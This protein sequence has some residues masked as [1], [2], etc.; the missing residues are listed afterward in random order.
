MVANLLPHP[1]ATVD[2][3]LF[4]S[5]V[6]DINES[7]SR[8]GPPSANT[9]RK[10]SDSAFQKPLRESVTNEAAQTP[11]EAPP[12]VEDLDLEH[13][14]TSH[15]EKFHGVL[16][17]FSH[18]WDGSLG[19][20]RATKH[21]IYLIEDAHPIAC[22]PYRA[23]PKA[24]EAEQMEVKRM[25]AANVIESGQSA[26]ASP[27]VL[28]PKSDGSLRFCVDYRRLNAVIVMDDYSLP[29]MD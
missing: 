12:T 6:L 25:R 27:V 20:I 1:T 23:G 26:W 3:E 17:N 18:M 13:V 28:V 14:P 15:R 5:D 16:R 9:A 2:T 24:R 22:H 4:L 7:E 21:H 29:R 8:P 10:N 11:P 19:A